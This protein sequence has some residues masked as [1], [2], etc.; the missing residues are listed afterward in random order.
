MLLQDQASPQEPVALS[1]TL[2]E[3]VVLSTHGLVG[4]VASSEGTRHGLLLLR[5]A[6]VATRTLLH[7]DS[8]FESVT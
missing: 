8:H 7:F 3:H 6:F 1:D 4:Q 5:Q 2:S